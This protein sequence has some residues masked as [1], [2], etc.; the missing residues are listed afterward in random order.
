MSCTFWDI[1]TQLSCS[2]HI[3]VLNE[4]ELLLVSMPGS[5]QFCP[6]ISVHGHNCEVFTV[7]PALS[8]HLDFLSAVTGTPLPDISQNGAHVDHFKDYT[9]TV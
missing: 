7:F 8:L 5:A 3:E 6:G 9:A 2:G 4:W 1:V